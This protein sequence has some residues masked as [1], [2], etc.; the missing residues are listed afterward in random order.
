MAKSRKDYEA[1]GDR[2]LEGLAEIDYELDFLKEWLPEKMSDAD[3]RTAVEAA[4]AELGVSGPKM[5][6]RVVGAVMKK[7]K[8][9]ADAGLVKQI[10]TE[11]L[12]E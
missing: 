2:G 6:G 11:L 9:V 1:A 3:V 10:A 7:H 4:I 8:G 12:A 5:A